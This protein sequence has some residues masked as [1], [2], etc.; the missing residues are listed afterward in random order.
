MGR[1][2]GY[3]PGGFMFTFG[4]V[5]CLALR[6]ERPIGAALATRLSVGSG[7]DGVRG[8]YAALPTER[9]LAA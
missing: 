5:G 8:L 4:S 7:V 6:S 9:F 3:A 2:L 1:A